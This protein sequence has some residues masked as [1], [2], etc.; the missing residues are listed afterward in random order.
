MRY[1]KLDPAGDYSFGNG[2]SD[3]FIDQPEAVAQSVTTR[4]NLW[5][6]QWF[7]DK[8]EGTDWTTSVLGKYTEFKRDA[9]IRNRI[10][11]TQGVDSLAAF[12][13]QFDGNTRTYNVQALVNTI[14]GQ[15]TI[16]TSI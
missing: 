5:T 6:G 1:R 8:T 9:L 4:L 2:L 11:G 10:L 14:Y 3:F 15:V 7:L 13:S 12:A 16:A